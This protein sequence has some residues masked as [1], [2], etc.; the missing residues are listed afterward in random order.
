MMNDDERMQRESSL[1][2]TIRTKL[3]EFAKACADDAELV[4]LHQDAF[5]ADYQEDEYKL[6]GMAAKYAGLRGKEVRV[7]RKNRSSLG[8]DGTIQ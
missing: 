3:P 7:I 6:L 4:L 8:L 1:I 2:A 5:A